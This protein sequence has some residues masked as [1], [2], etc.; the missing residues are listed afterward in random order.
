MFNSNF[1]KS[2]IWQAKG[3]RQQVTKQL[4]HRHFFGSCILSFCPVQYVPEPK[5]KITAKLGIYA[6]HLETNQST[7]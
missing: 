2:F 6:D 1:L 5:I 3:L 7:H 4:L